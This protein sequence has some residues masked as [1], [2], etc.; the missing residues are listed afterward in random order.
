MK[1]VIRLT[2]SDLA[3]IVKRVIS[4]QKEVQ[5]LMKNCLDKKYY[6]DYIL[7]SSSTGQKF[8]TW[9]ENEKSVFQKKDWNLTI[10][11]NEGTPEIK[12]PKTTPPSILMVFN[13]DD[14]MISD[15]VKKKF[16]GAVSNNTTKNGN[17]VTTSRVYSSKNEQA[18]SIMFKKFIDEILSLCTTKT[19]TKDSNSSIFFRN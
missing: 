16:D 10:Y 19:N 13:T 2:E 18:V 3:R 5:T 17:N 11:F 6:P 14:S 12:S 8:V 4:E 15:I 9:G 1:K 7:K